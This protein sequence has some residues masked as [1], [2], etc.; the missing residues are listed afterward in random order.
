MEGEDEGEG[1]D[2]GREKREDGE[3]RKKEREGKGKR[4]RNLATVLRPHGLWRRQICTQMIRVKCAM[5]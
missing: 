4:R 2:R 5:C 1:G 3:K